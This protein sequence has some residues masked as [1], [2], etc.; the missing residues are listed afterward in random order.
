MGANFSHHHRVWWAYLKENFYYR[1][2]TLISDMQANL[3]LTFGEMLWLTNNKE[4]RMMT[5]KKLA[6][7]R[8]LKTCSKTR[9]QDPSYRV[10]KCW[11]SSETRQMRRTISAITNVIPNQRSRPT[12][13]SSHKLS[14]VPFLFSFFF[15]IPWTAIPWEPCPWRCS[16]GGNTKAERVERYIEELVSNIN[17]TWKR[18]L[19]WNTNE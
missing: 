9:D 15:F 1:I 11:I 7:L 14:H 18:K 13:N 8:E 16:T 17:Q 3:A 19:V 12:S 10:F 4:S 2:N 6:E 5:V